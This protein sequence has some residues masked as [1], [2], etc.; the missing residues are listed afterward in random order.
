MDPIVEN[1]SST[2]PSTQN[3]RKIVCV[4]KIG[5][6][7][8][9]ANKNNQDF[10][11]SL[12][13]MKVVL[14]GCG[15]GKHSEVGVRIFSQ[16][17]SRKAKEYFD[18]G[19]TVGEAEFVNIVNGVFVRMLELCSD[20]AFLFQNYCFTILAYFELDEEF[21]VYSCGDGYIITEDFEGNISFEK[22][23][24]GEYPCYYCYNFVDKSALTAYQEGVTFK[25]TRFSKSNYANVGVATDGLRFSENLF[26][27]EWNKLLK[28]LHEGKGA[29]IEKLVNRNNLQTGLFHDDISICF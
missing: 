18:R 8:T 1:K 9:F 28:F 23:D 24:D 21:V 2:N 6:D 3:M 19:E 5:S 26:A 22:L 4:S 27:A 29:Q 15:S 20:T 25:V 11:F 10:A 12:M 13:N 7:H 16:L 17:F 14:D